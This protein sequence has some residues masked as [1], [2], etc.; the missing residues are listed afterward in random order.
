MNKRS[1]DRVRRWDVL[2]ESRSDGLSTAMGRSTTIAS[3]AESLCAETALVELAIIVPTLNECGN[4]LPLI[5]RL[6]RALGGIRWEVIFVDDDSRDGSIDLLR[7]LQQ[8]MPHVRVIRRIGRRGLASACIEG[9]LASAAPYLAVMDADLQHDEMILPEM[10]R[11]LK[12][13]D[14]DIVIGS[15]FMSGGSADLGLSQRR[16]WLSRLGSSL[17]RMISG[18]SLSDPMS[19]FFML[20]RGFLEETVRSLSGHGFKILLDLFAS[21]PRKVRFAEVPYAFRERH[22]G[23]SKLDSVVMLE[24]LT[25]LGDKLLGDYV[26]IRFVIFILVGLVGVVVHLTILALFYKGVGLTFYPAQVIATLVAMTFNFNLNNLLTYRD[27][28]LR[29]RWLIY[30][31]LSF[32]L[33]CSVGAIANFQIA[34]MLY[35]IRVPWA[36]AGLLGA[37][38]GAVWNYGVSSTFTWRQ[39]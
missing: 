25:L 3:A 28:R 15:R 17:S 5:E 23:E 18:A 31:H 14:L 35:E 39:R 16:L 19:G 24:Y 12:Q 1:F 4:L 36:L 27:R 10:M 7:D 30:G 33:V 32:Y 29:G 13:S 22:A 6:E 38:V 34:E 8:R 20:R 9:M 26:P 21:S 2:P 37:V 11:W